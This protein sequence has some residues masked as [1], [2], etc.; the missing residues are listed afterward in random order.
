M[1]VVVVLW[2]NQ[3]VTVVLIRHA[4]KASSP[5]KDPEL[6]PE[7]ETRAQELVNVLGDAG[8]DAIF[9]SQLKR[10]KRTAE[11]LR[12]HLGLTLTEIQ[13]DESALQTYVDDVVTRL[14]SGHWGEVVLVVSHSGTVPMIAQGLGA[15]ATGAIGDTFDKLFIISVPRFFGSVTIVRGRYGAAVCPT[16]SPTP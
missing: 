16:P 8:V 12:A 9:T 3:P 5:A 15:P 14:R 1:C 6:L 10:T 2:L 13:Y 11:D 7:G 4:E